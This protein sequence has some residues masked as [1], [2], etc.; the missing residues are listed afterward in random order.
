MIRSI[1]RTPKLTMRT[2][3]MIIFIIRKMMMIWR[4]SK[5]KITG[6]RNKKRS[7][8]PFN[9]VSRHT[10][11]IHTYMCAQ[12]TYTHIYAHICVYIYIYIIDACVYVAV[13]V[14]THI[15]IYIYIYIHICTHFASFQTVPGVEIGVVFF[16]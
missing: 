4:N 14:H 7:F 6:K 16:K 3:V 1:I 12:C 2:R 8:R 9:Y 5:R 10:M 15:Y 13:C 11:Y